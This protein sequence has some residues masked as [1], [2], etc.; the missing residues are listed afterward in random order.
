MSRFQHDHENMAALLDLTL[1]MNEATD[2]H[3]LAVRVL[4]WLMARDGVTSCGIWLEQSGDLVCLAQR[5]IEP[6]RVIPA[7]QQAIESAALAP[8]TSVYQQDA[9]LTILPLGSTNNHRGALV[10]A[11]QAS[12]EPGELLLLRAVAAHLAATIARLHVRPSQHAEAS[13]RTWEVFLAHAVHEIKNPLASIKGYTDLLLRRAAKD[14]TDLYHKGLATISQQVGRTTALLDQLSDITRVST[15]SFPID[16]HVMDFTTITNRV[17]QEYQAADQQHTI[18]FDKDDTVLP[19]RFDQVRMAQVVGAVIGNA[20]KF[21]FDGGVVRVLL[22]RSKAVDGTAQARLS[23]SDTGVGVPVGEQERVF[24]RFFQGS[25]IR[26]TYAGLGVGLY[27]A[28]AIVNL[29]DGRIWLE[30][31]RGLGTTCHVALPLTA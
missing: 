19:G 16:R 31:E 10:V 21:S 15:G 12:P 13:D 8:Q 3:A 28:R 5:N 2:P 9:R 17:V 23:I 1:A 11:T 30:S 26:G 18:A 4:D 7:I 22:R 25:N 27:I 29:H 24:E 20:L 6:D 14:P